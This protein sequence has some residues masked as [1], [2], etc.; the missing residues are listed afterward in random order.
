[1]SA[2]EGG[3]LLCPSAWSEIVH[4]SACHLAAK[5]SFV[6]FGLLANRFVCAALAVDLV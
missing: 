3:R 6:V 2:R 4:F 1:V 5:N